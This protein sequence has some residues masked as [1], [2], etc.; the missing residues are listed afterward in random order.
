MSGLPWLSLL[1]WLPILGIPLLWSVRSDRAVNR[2]ALGIA[3]VELVVSL[4]VILA[5]DRTLPTFQFQEEHSWIETLRISYRLGVD[6]L[7]APF[8][9]LTGLLFFGTILVSELGQGQARQRLA[10]LLVLEGV[11][12]GIFCALDLILFFL[13]WEMTLL[14]IY[15]LV[16]L[17]GIGPHRRQAALKYTL[18]ML[19]GGVPLLFGL[20]LAALSR[21]E[22]GMVFSLP[23]LLNLSIPGSAQTAIFLLL[24]LGFGVKIPVWPLHTWLPLLAM[25]GPF[26]VTAVMTGL[27]LGAYG[28]LRFALPLAPQAAHE[29]QWLL[30]GLGVVG[31]I[32]GG[33]VS[34][35]QS[36]LRLLLAYGSMSHVGLV[37]LG[38]AALTP[39]GVQGAQFHL[40]SFA[41]TTGGLFLLAQGVHRRLGSTDLSHMGG[42][43]R[44]M[45]MAASAVLVLGLASIGVP[46]TVGFPG[47]HLILVG[48]L[49]AF[50]GAGLASLGGSILGAAAFLGFYRNAFLG[51]VVRAEVSQLTDLLPRERWLAGIW[52]LLVLGGGFVPRLVLDFS[53]SSVAGW[54]ARM[55]LH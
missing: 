45:P 22:Q 26:A 2:V 38:L 52:V 50:M 32:Y 42:I 33:L 28:L 7:S 54:L 20:I 30:A 51:P 1:V 10:F 14:P 8:L 46:L 43:A 37:V 39:Q 55:A 12:M 34:L 44:T 48:T 15:L 53:R 36:N 47:E 41:L 27:K 6:G 13:F 29:F 5:M 18:L 9:P 49:N 24:V 35:A 16:S 4:L 25:E 40:L 11:T 3:G 23:A 19:V 17:W 31:V 21:P